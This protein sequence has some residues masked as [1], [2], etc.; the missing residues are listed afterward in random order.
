MLRRPRIAR[1]QARI[2]PGCRA[3][4]TAHVPL[5]PCK[6]GSCIC[7]D[8]AFSA[9]IFQHLRGWHNSCFYSASPFGNAPGEH[10]GETPFPVIETGFPLKMP[11]EGA[12]SPHSE[13]LDFSRGV[14]PAP[15]P[16]RSRSFEQYGQALLWTLR[17]LS[18]LAVPVLVTGA[19]IG[20]LR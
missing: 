13:R 2:V 6:T 5:Q 18:A 15:H 7:K 11:T 16:E 4:R 17:D 19:G 3:L 10:A 9:V 1:I 20:N 14:D 8:P 12:N